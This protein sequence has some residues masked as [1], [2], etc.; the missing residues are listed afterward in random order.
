MT[1]WRS[2]LGA[3]TANG[4][5]VWRKVIPEQLPA[6]A[7]TTDGTGHGEEGKATTGPETKP[8]GKKQPRRFYGSIPLDPDKAG[9]QVAAIAKEILF[10]LSRPNGAGLKITL[11]IEGTAASGYP[12]DVIDVIRA[13]L[14][15]LKLD[16]S[17]VGFE[18]S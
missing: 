13:N 16:T 8:A 17:E 5:L 3:A 4:L 11:E 12:Q 18:E 9:F 15:G 2:T 10:E 14:R 7:E 6:G 1:Q